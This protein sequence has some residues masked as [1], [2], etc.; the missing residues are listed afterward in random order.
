MYLFV[1]GKNKTIAS[2]LLWTTELTCGLT[3]LAWKWFIF[4]PKQEKMLLVWQG[5][6]GFNI[7]NYLLSW[8]HGG[9]TTEAAKGS[10]GTQT[11]SYPGCLRSCLRWVGSSRASTCHWGGAG[12]WRV[13]QQHSD[14]ISHQVLD[15][16]ASTNE[17]WNNIS[18]NLVAHI[19]LWGFIGS[20][21]CPVGII[22]PSP[23]LQSSSWNIQISLQR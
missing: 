19:I 2:F 16:T 14:L 1:I 10:L 22:L 3:S 18:S 5:D 9:N 7:N 23:L 20:H 8:G 17:M 11:Q 4:S 15:T 6:R 12:M 13:K 21:C